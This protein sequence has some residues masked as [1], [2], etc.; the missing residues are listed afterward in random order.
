MQFVDLPS[1]REQKKVARNLA[2]AILKHPT[3]SAARALAKR[4]LS[5]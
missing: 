2:R 4:Y 1:P 5:N 3:R